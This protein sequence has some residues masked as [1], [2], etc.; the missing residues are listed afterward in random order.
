MASR[1]PVTSGPTRRTQQR[2][3]PPGEATGL[4]QHR[5]R[6]FTGFS[7]LLS[8]KYALLAHRRVTYRTKKLPIM[9]IGSPD[10]LVSLSVARL[11]KP[12]DAPKVQDAAGHF[13]QPFPPGY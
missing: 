11:P 10:I 8:T 12:G 4:S 9:I 2:R 7:G 3:R 6:R 1:P 5:S 13:R